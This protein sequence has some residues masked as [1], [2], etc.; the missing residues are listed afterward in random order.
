MTNNTSVLFLVVTSK[1]WKTKNWKSW[2]VVIF[3]W[4]TDTVSLVKKT[5]R[6]EEK[7]KNKEKQQ[8]TDILLCQNIA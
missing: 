4:T 8:Q 6:N 7:N 2:T 3:S 5:K 1:W